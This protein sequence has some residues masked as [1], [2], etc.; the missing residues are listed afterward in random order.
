VGFKF[1]DLFA[2]IGGFR[3]GAEANGGVCVFSSEIDKFAR[4]TYAL[5]HLDE[6]SGD[7]TQIHEGQIPDHDVL[8][9]GF[10]CQP[11]SI[12]GLRQGFEDTTRGTLFFDVLR[13]MKAKQPQFALLENVKGFTFHDKG[14]TMDTA[15]KALEE[16]GYTPHWQVLNSKDFGVPQ[17]R[18][19]WYCVAIRKDLG[20]TR[21]RF[22]EGRDAGLTIRSIIDKRGE[23]LEL[24][25]HEQKLIDY[26]FSKMSLTPRVKH[27][28]LRYSIA[29]SRGRYGVYSYLTPQNVLRFYRGDAQK[30]GMSEYQYYSLDSC[31]PTISA[32]WAPKLWDVRRWLSV[33]EC[34]RLQGFPDS[35]QFNVSKTQAYKQLGNSVTVPVVQAIIRAIIESQQKKTAKGC[36]GDILEKE[37]D[38]KLTLSD[39]AWQG[40]QAHKEKHSKAGNG[41]GYSLFTKDSPYTNT[42]SARYYKDGLEALIAQDGKN[43]RMLSPRECLRLQGFPDSF[44]FDVSKTQAYKQCGNS[45][46][47]PVVQA[48]IERIVPNLRTA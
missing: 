22:P 40:K 37:P 48:I 13:I 33:L 20:I 21:F 4:Q 19:R 9:A 36:V 23:N 44:Q 11:F 26:H 42:I 29:A 5:N 24:K 2:G 10:P 43:P 7:I 32:T 47:V 45:V 46:T 30:T 35:F 16:I 8:L 17:N 25:E 18:Q 31:A 15:L 38:P 6:P 41:F 34:Q 27:D 1:I 12:A 3:L 28:Y 39:R 14:R